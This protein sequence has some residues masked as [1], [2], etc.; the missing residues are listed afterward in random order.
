MSED[1]LRKITDTVIKS[2]SA[3]GFAGSLK[4][5]YEIEAS[6]T[7]GWY[8]V[9]S[10]PGVKP[11][12]SVWLDRYLQGQGRELY[13]GI[14]SKKRSDLISFRNKIADERD[15][16][17]IEHEDQE[18][19]KGE[20][21]LKK[22]IG[23]DVRSKFIEGQ[24]EDEQYW[25]GRY[26]SSVDATDEAIDFFESA[27]TGTGE[28]LVFR[29]GNCQ[30][31]TVNKYERDPKARAACL[32]KF[33]CVCKV[34]DMNFAEEYGDEIGHGFIHVHH[35]EMLSGGVRDVNAETDLIPVCPNCHSMLH[36]RNP[37]LEVRELREIRTSRKAT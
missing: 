27:L 17:K 10:N 13:Y 20:Y 34:C 6:D 4:S 25:L 29:E 16:R 18:K 12:I 30:Q 22:S 32:A 11:G 5:S 8:V 31:V 14:Y 35:I 7:D 3:R 26:A 9:V 21:L 37:P 2:L 1:V 23:V 19:R 28:T 24:S 36:R 33:G 15:I